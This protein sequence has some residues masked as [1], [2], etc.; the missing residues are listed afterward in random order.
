M[1]KL[2][3]KKILI[4]QILTLCIITLSFSMIKIRNYK[5]NNL[6]IT[7]SSKINCNKNVLET[8]K[9]EKEQKNIPKTIYLT[10]DDGPAPVITDALLDVLKKENVKA[11]FF[12]V[13][14]EI[15]GREKILK[16]IYEE[17]HGI[18]LHTYSHNY[19]KL[20]SSNK[21]FLDE[22]KKVQDQINKILN[23]SPKTLRFPG[24]SYKHL[25]KTFLK[26]IHENGYKIYDWNV[27]TNDAVNASLNPQQ[28][29]KNAQKY[30][31]NPDRLIILMHTNSNNINTVKA[32]PLIIKY[33]RDLG[34]EFKPITEKTEEY[35]YAPM[36]K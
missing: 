32:L 33:Y 10:F 4:L 14:K 27:C 17:G 7:T 2:S 12:V 6:L 15:E 18:G 30:K 28:L 36:N 35:Y 8:D 21:I 29:L 13:G 11:T 19:K 22:M 20:Y 31:G 16:R 9:S 26:Q 23:I 25:S 1:K 3:K 24:G 34:C 5:I